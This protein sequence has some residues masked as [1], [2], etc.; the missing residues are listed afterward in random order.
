MTGGEI[1][2]IQKGLN[3]IMYL[4]EEDLSAIMLDAFE[5]RI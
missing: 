2:H 5:N 4:K 1:Y 3:G